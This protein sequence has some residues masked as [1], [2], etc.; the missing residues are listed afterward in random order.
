MGKGVPKSKGSVCVLEELGE[1]GMV[2][3]QCARNNDFDPLLGFTSR[4]RYFSLLTSIG[5]RISYIRAGGIELYTY[6]GL[7]LDRSG[8][9]C[10]SESAMQSSHAHLKGIIH[11]DLKP[12]NVLVSH[13]GGQGGRL[14]S[15]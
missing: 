1:E 12:T 8:W 4:F 5:E 14:T 10:S 6:R 3:F 15:G 2:G 11:R 7:F 9:G 13:E